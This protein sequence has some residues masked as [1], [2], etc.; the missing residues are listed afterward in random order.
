[1]QALAGYGGKTRKAYE[2][3]GQIANEAIENIRTIASLTRE[4]TFRQM[5]FENIIK[6]HRIAIHGYLV[7]A[8]GFGAAQAIMYLAYAL[9]FW[10][11]SQLV[12]TLEYTQKQM[13]ISMFTLVFSAMVCST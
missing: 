10:Y 3:S 9:A 5:Y 4:E 8:I 6:P 1:M 7:A 2:E 12:A 11:G 13:M